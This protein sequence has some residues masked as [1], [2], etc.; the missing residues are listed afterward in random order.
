MSIEDKPWIADF[1]RKGSKK[2][3]ETP[4]D[5]SLEPRY[6]SQASVDILVRPKPDLVD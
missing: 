5:A 6:Q 2:N 4:R 3:I 1:P